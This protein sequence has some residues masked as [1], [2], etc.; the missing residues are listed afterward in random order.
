MRL[1][2]KRKRIF[3]IILSLI[4]IILL[5]PIYFSVAL[6]V[7]KISGSPIIFKQK[8]VGYNQKMFIMYKFRTMV[9]NAEDLKEKYQNLNEAEGPVFKIKN[10]PRFTKIGKFLSHSNLDELPQFFNVL[11]G[12]M[13]IVGFRAPTPDEVK[14]Y[15]NWHFERFK[16]SPGMT[17]LWAIS[18]NHKKYSFDE[19]IKMDIGY[20]Q[21]ISFLL[22]L[23]IITLTALNLFRK[24]TKIK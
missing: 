13:S 16:G 11:K 18:G 12:D 4:A 2:L 8:R 10:D 7:K 21:N 23:K 3:D 24:I 1:Y 6:A 15:K 5:S 22:D 20:N 17:S 14:K 19:W 9:K